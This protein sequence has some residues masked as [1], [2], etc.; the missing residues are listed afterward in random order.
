MGLDTDLDLLMIVGDPDFVL[1]PTVGPTGDLDG[2]DF[3]E[4]PDDVQT[5][6]PHDSIL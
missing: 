6:L 2:L 3:S 4:A 1:G 5:S